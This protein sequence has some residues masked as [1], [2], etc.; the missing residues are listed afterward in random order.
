MQPLYKI[1]EQLTH[2]ES[3]EDEIDPETFA[4][5]MEALEGDLEAK[6]LSVGMFIKG[7]L[8][9]ADFVDTEIKRL[10]ER[11]RKHIKTADDVKEYLR[12]IVVEHKLP[13]STNGIITL[14]LRKGSQRLEITGK[15]PAQFVKTETVEK[16]DKRGITA[17]MKE[18]ASF[19]GCALVRSEDSL[20]I[21]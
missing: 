4:D 12:G 6:A 14:S 7:Q 1:A 10:A 2:L 15:A 20:V 19:D 5:T 21:K 9:A 11:K 3:I 18:G 16:V 13:K 8:D 17:A